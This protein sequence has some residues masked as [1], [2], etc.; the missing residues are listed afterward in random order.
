MSDIKNEKTEATEPEAPADDVETVELVT[1]DDAGEEPVPPSTKA[2]SRRRRIFNWASVMVGLLGLA[3]AIYSHLSDQRSREPTFHV[4]PERATVFN[5]DTA[6]PAGVMLLDGDGEVIAGDVHALTFYF[7]NDGTLPMKAEHVRKPIRVSID[8]PDAFILGPPAVLK[9]SREDVTQFQLE[10][11]GPAEI[12]LRF[13]TLELNEG[14]RCQLLYQGRADAGI[15]FDGY[16]EESG[17]PVPMGRIDRVAALFFLLVHVPLMFILF[18]IV[19]PATK[20]KKSDGS[21]RRVFV[22]NLFADIVSMIIGLVI[23]VVAM[24]AFYSLSI[25]SD[26]PDDLIPTETKITKVQKGG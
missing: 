20:L 3:F 26:I 14:A 10:K 9:R 18:S 25:S 12:E 11:I 23:F 2:L 4:V 5:A 21:R 8:D 13:D 7:W 16:I 1:D 6:G 17:A 22:H 19:L 15:I 24:F